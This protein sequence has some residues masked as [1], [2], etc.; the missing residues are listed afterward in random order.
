LLAALT[1]CK[2]IISHF[3]DKIAEIFCL[4]W[5]T[6]AL[7]LFAVDTL[8]EFK[9]WVMKVSPHKLEGGLPSSGFKILVII[10]GIV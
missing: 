2:K 10:L 5:L 9:F 3:L 7:F 4:K 1:S 6:L 8:R